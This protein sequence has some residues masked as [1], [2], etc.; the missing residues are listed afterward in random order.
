MYNGKE[1]VIIILKNKLQAF[2]VKTL[3][4]YGVG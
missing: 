2:V 4:G 1:I 3:I